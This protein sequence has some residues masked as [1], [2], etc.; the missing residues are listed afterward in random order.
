LLLLFVIVIGIGIFI[1]VGVVVGVRNITCCILLVYYRTVNQNLVIKIFFK[2]VTEA[3]S[4][5]KSKS[6]N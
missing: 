6:I 4:Q 2:A 5:L 1:V 3:K